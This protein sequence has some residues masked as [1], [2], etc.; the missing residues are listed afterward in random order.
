MSRVDP[1][2]RKWNALIVDDDPGLQGL[3]LTLL[4][5]D[6]FSVDCAPN[7]R[8]AF[9]YLKRRSYSVILLDLMMPDVNG[10]E[11]LDRLERDSP[12]ILRRVII[13][14]GAAQR[15]ID[16]LDETRVWG[17][18]RKPFDIEVLMNAARNCSRGQA[19]VTSIGTPPPP[20]ARV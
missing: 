14:T 19:R 18:I 10:F 16:E 7:G 12:G 6:G 1:P 3:F 4:G 20:Q 5:R 9:E 15:V 2:G 13:M 8:V 11:L 17:V